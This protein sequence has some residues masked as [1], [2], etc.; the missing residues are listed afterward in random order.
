MGIEESTYLGAGCG[1][2]AGTGEEERGWEEGLVKPK[3]GCDLKGAVGPERFP[4]PGYDEDILLP[5]LLLWLGHS[6]ILIIWIW[7]WM[8]GNEW[9]NYYF[10]WQ[11]NRTQVS[12][13]D[14][15]LFFLCL[16]L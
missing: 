13:S 11:Q 8:N 14:V 2:G 9:N 10:V 5:P 16:G 1:E 3:V 15:T 7:I 4:K 6:F 12:S